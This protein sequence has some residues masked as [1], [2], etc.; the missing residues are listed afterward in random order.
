MAYPTYD[1]RAS[2]G[3]T[4]PSEAV[5]TYASNLSQYFVDFLV[6]TSAGF[7]GT[8]TK[9]EWR[10]F[11][12][13]GQTLDVLNQGKREYSF[14]AA[15]VS[16][17]P[18]SSHFYRLDVGGRRQ[19]VLS[20]PYASRLERFK[21]VLQLAAVS[22]TWT[23]PT[24]DVLTNLLYVANE[25]VE[26]EAKRPSTVP[27]STVHVAQVQ[28]HLAEMLT[29]YNLQGAC[30]SME[31]V[32]GYLLDMEADYCANLNVDNFCHTVHRLHP[33]QYANSLGRTRPNRRS[34]K[35]IFSKCPY[36]G[37][38]EPVPLGAMY[39]V[40][41]KG[42]AVTC[43]R[44][45]NVITPTSFRMAS[46]IADAPR[47][48]VDCT[49]SSTT[50]TITVITPMMPANGNVRTFLDELYR[51]M[52]EQAPLGSRD[53]VKELQ[54]MVSQKIQLHFNSS[55]L[56]AFEMDLVQAMIRQLDFVN[57]MCPN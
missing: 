13:N 34:L 16:I 45:A 56:G 3:S 1:D 12:L 18:M 19:L 32:Y 47:F 10:Q 20:I 37:C 51:R 41:I 40:H 42:E 2:E 55:N 4:Q 35:D 22:P 8:S 52:K 15:Q 46:F 31:E 25:I 28:A 49:L 53:G 6:K 48:S 11:V 17:Q 44:C 30:T 36:M 38:G 54:A 23:P 27:I 7:L 57:K 5:A 33:V 24:Y 43:N 50:S 26:A 29:M 21:Y 14:R 39:K 9:Y